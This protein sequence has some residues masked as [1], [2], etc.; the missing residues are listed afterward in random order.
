MSK[1]TLWIADLTA[2]LGL[3]KAPPKNQTLFL[4]PI[5]GRPFDKTIHIDTIFIKHPDLD[6]LYKYSPA[7]YNIAKNKLV[8]SLYEISPKYGFELTDKDRE[9]IRSGIFIRSGSIYQAF[10]GDISS[11]T[12]DYVDSAC[13]AYERW[14]SKNRKKMEPVPSNAEIDVMLDAALYD[15]QK[16]FSLYEQSIPNVVKYKVRKMHGVYLCHFNVDGC[17]INLENPRGYYD[18]V[19]DIYDIDGVNILEADSAARSLKIN[20]KITELKSR[21]EYKRRINAIKTDYAVFDVMAQKL[22]RENFQT[23]SQQKIKGLER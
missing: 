23:I 10:K 17:A 20:K 16:S 8:V 19:S 2:L 22:M 1:K 12:S 21:A 6:Y 4:R 5:N 3:G 15:F 11:K 14:I 13:F 7:H 18:S 9:M